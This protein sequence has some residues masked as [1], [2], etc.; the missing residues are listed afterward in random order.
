MAESFVAAR[1][2]T[3]FACTGSACEDTCCQV[4]NP[5]VPISERDYRRVEAALAGE[6]DAGA[7]LERLFAITPP[8][9]GAFAILQARDD[10]S[11][12]ALDEDRLCGL[13]TK[14]GEAALP[15]ACAGYP[16]AVTRLGERFEL[17][18]RLSCPE[19]ARLC[20]LASD[21]LDPEP[22]AREQLGRGA[23]AFALD[24]TQPLDPYLALFEP[25]RQAIVRLGSLE[26]FPVAGRQFFVAYLA[27]RL[28][29]FYHRSTAPFDPARLSAELRE[30]TR[31]ELLDALHARFAATPPNDAVPLTAIAALLS[32]RLATPCPP[33]FRRVV[34]AVAQRYADEA[35][36]AASPR[37][38]LARLIALGPLRLADAHAHRRA[39]IDADLAAC[40]Q[41]WLR[42]Y[43]K[44]YW[45]Q[46]WYVSS[47]SLLEH[48]LHLALRAATI[49][50]LFLGHP[51]LDAARAAP[52]EPS[53]RAAYDRLAVEI[54]YSTT[55]AFDHTE[56]ARSH[57]ARTIADQ[58][59]C[60]LAHATAL[61]KL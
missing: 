11:C 3:R 40:L 55:R 53:R 19:V 18:G 17:T 25:V 44:D 59:L 35:A 9:P 24:D 49:R 41:R 7:Q 54:F 51:A 50:F 43:Y 37:A 6:R 29:P 46:D 28:A 13:R 8:R 14:H 31:P 12:A 1:Y 4:S 10:G 2:M 27:H 56:P 30:L 16:R 26:R 23:L 38:P 21:A 22:I 34:E 60:T 15:Q 45:I 32:A 47:A 39:A 42:N 36:I 33:A 61:L 48:A 52:D 58:N 57:L 5:P 20:L